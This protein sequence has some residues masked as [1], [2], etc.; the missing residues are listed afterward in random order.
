MLMRFQPGF[1]FSV[2]DGA[3]ITVAFLGAWSL[4]PYSLELAIIVLFVVAHFFL[5]CNVVR[6]S[7]LSELIWAGAFVILTSLSLVFNLFS[8]WLAAA[9]NVLLTVTLV[10]IELRKPSYHGIFWK[11][12]NPGLPDWFKAETSQVQ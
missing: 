10:F 5:F 8:W 3:I 11:K 7:R 6:M 12:V 1:R 4:Y 9:S 2:F